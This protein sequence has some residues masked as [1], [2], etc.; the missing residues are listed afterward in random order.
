MGH[1]DIKIERPN[2]ESDAVVEAITIKEFDPHKIELHLQK[3]FGYDPGSLERNFFI[4]YS[5]ADDFSGLWK[6]YL[7]FIPGIKFEYPMSGNIHEEKL[8]LEGIKSARTR[9]KREE[10]LTEVYHLMINMKH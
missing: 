8:E 3:L 7:D 10:K 6:K 4:I 1:P 9:Y 2:G 5:E